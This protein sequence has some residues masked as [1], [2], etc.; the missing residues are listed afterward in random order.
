[1]YINIEHN[2]EWWD[3]GIEIDE[4]IR[5]FCERLGMVEGNYS[6]YTP[7]Y[8]YLQN[9]NTNMKQFNQLKLRLQRS[10]RL[11]KN[12]NGED[13]VVKCEANNVS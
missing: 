6:K 1:M 13:V 2:I 4:I 5:G 11:K 3:G 12:I 7:C 9:E 8:L 10:K